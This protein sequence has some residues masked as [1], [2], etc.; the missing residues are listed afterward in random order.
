MCIRDRSDAGVHLVVAE[1]DGQVVGSN[2]AWELSPITGVGPITIAPEA[3]DASLGRRL[4]HH[5]LERAEQRGALGVR[6]VQAAYHNR[7]LALYSSLGFDAVEPLSV[8]QGPALGIAIA[9]RAVRPAVKGDL[10]ACADLGTA[11]HG[12]S[13]AGELSR[14]IADGAAMVVEREGRISGYCTGIGFLAHAVGR[15]NE[16]VMALIGAAPAFGGPGFLLPTRNARLLRWCLSRGLRLV[17]P[18]TLMKK[19]FY[20]QP[21]GAYLPSVLF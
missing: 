14:A 2:M 4:M 6:L 21:K 10:E 11:L 7:S 1:R 15:G 13:R 5:V 20:R 17:Q 19:G 12:F 18:M 8:L 16:D 9:G 3:Q